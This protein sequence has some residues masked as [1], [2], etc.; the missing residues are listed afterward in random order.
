MFYNRGKTIL[1][2]DSSLSYLPRRHF[3]FYIMIINFFDLMIFVIFFVNCISRSRRPEL[4]CKKVY[5]KISERKRL[6]QGLFL[7]KVAR[8]GNRTTLQT[9]SFDIHQVLYLTFLSL[10]CFANSDRLSAHQ[11]KLHGTPHKSLK[12]KIPGL[13]SEIV[14]GK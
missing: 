8:G 13:V 6:C 5:L 3:L 4:L 7:N 14:S 1:S 10:Q 12:V 9:T 2:I 11:Q